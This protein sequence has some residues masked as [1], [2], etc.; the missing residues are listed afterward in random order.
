MADIFLT[1]EQLAAR[2][3]EELAEVQ[4]IERQ[5]EQ[6]HLWLKHLAQ[7]RQRYIYLP[8]LPKALELIAP[9]KIFNVWDEKWVIEKGSLGQFYIP[10][11]EKGQKYSQAL[12]VPGI[13]REAVMV[14]EV[15]GGRK[16][17]W[18][19]YD[20]IEVAQ[21]IIGVTRYAPAATNL[22]PYGV[23]IAAGQEPSDE[24]ILKANGELTK[25]L[26]QIAKEALA[27]ARIDPRSI[28]NRHLKALD[29]VRDATVR[30][31]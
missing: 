13:V 4:R 8:S 3:P 10:P 21:D 6:D 18:L 17:Q 16:M 29:F 12:T 26:F 7:Q 30:N 27:L 23:F 15:A 2:T 31:L 19:L 28:S 11:C 9:V 1:P 5:T 20:G 22:T 24:E 25:T 14:E